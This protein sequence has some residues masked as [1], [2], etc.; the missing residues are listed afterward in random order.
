MTLSSP[1]MSTA[2]NP[3][4]A[5]I[6]TPGIAKTRELITR[7]QTLVDSQTPDSTQ[8][9]TFLQGFGVDIQTIVKPTDATSQITTDHLVIRSDST[10]ILLGNLA[11]R[12]EAKFK[13]EPGSRDQLYL[14][15][16]E[17]IIYG[18]QTAEQRMDTDFAEL[19]GILALQR[20]ISETI[21][22]SSSQATYQPLQE[23]FNEV[24]NIYKAT[25]I[26][27]LVRR[28]EELFAEDVLGDKLPTVKDNLNADQQRQASHLLEAIKKLLIIN[29]NP[30]ELS[31]DYKELLE[32][33][34]ENQKVN[35]RGRTLSVSDT[36]R[37]SNLALTRYELSYITNDLSRSMRRESWESLNLPPQQVKELF[38]V[39]SPQL[40]S[41]LFAGGRES[42]EGTAAAGTLALLKDPRAIPVFIEHLRRFGAGH[43]TNSVVYA[44][45]EIV[46]NPLR[47]EDLEQTIA[48]ATPLQ[49]KI[50]NSWFRESNTV[51]YKIL[52]EGRKG[53]GAGYALASMVQQAEQ[54]IA[55]G[56]LLEIAVDIAKSQ[57]REIDPE[58]IKAFFYNNQFTDT[59][60]IEETLLQDI[61]QVATIIAKSKMTDW[62]LASPKLFNTLITPPDGDMAKFPKVIAKEG[63]GL[64]EEEIGKV[65]SL[66]QSGDLRRGVMARSIF[67]EGLLFLSSKDEGQQVMKN[68]LSVTTGANRDSERIR[69][70][71]TL[72][73][74][75]DGFG[76]FE[77][78]RK[79][80]LTEIVTD[81]RGKLVTT[82]AEKMEL[83]DNESSILNQR[84][85]ELMRSGIFEIIPQLLSKFNTQGRTEV[86]SVVREVG[87]HVVL[88]DFS[89]WRNNLP[90]SLEQLSIL[91]NEQRPA[92]LNP[93]TEVSIAVGVNKD[94]AQQGA[95]D[96]ISRIALEAKAHILD[97]YKLD[98]S[99][100]GIN[101][102]RARQ[103]ELIQSLKDATRSPDERKELGETKRG[104]DN[105]LR[106]VEGILGL[107]S[108]TPDRL[109]PIQLNKHISAI[110]NSLSS[111]PK[112]DQAALD[113][114]QINEV[115]ATQKEIG[116][117]RAIKARD[118]DD[119]LTLLKAGTEPRE[120]CQSYRSGS[121]NHC[122]PAYVVDAN[123][124]VINAEDDR[125]EILGRSIMKLT[126]IK[127]ENGQTH[128]AILLEPIYT[129]SEIA[130]T[131]QSIARVALEKAKATGAYLI[132]RGDV[133]V[134]TGANNEFAIP[135]IEREAQKLGMQYSVEDTEVYLPKSANPYE[136]SDSL[137]GEQSYFDIY[138]PVEGATVV[139]P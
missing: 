39:L 70:V 53:L 109:D 127:D 75:L 119:P 14:L 88:D 35:E 57:G 51:A 11:R 27:S 134:H 107:E 94:A 102:L 96:A 132:L 49:R 120:T 60:E 83:T 37:F 21:G 135:V 78:A 24:A 82:V 12:A 133:E 123:K 118:S 136:Y 124:R 32:P 43:T 100:G 95:I 73:R 42:W 48:Q 77:F 66:Y 19:G 54:H 97:V 139:K 131:Y 106:I 29:K 117:V 122:L 13:Y 91:T 47:V 87:R 79:D 113:L 38:D 10:N 9:N 116:N 121:F 62:K 115:L 17:A 67:A 22:T 15:G 8:I 26:K 76:K 65:A 3:E 5:K 7:Y 129:T 110:V 25:A 20:Y 55:R 23:R 103:A 6:E 114:S 101:V 93:G 58:I 125:G 50:I 126:H 40:I 44:L 71:F 4:V 16:D 128:S 33:L 64:T 30:T 90:T 80:S 89:E 52:E 2:T 99:Q 138:R 105:Q 111:F 92:W 41:N 34:M 63:L 56:D 28:G 61:D 104:V 31:D 36:V 72:L 108:L 98:F 85:F 81:L 46:N 74:S 84:L 68:I 18:D 137:G 112:L 130:A 1:E 59:S 69:D 86:A 45:E